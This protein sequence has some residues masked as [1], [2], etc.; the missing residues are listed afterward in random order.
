M[1]PWQYAALAAVGALCVGGAVYWMTRP[2]SDGWVAIPVAQG[3]L[4]GVFYA[5]PDYY[6]RGGVRVPM[7]APEAQR[8]ADA[9]GFVLP[10]PRMVDAIEQQATLLPFHA[11]AV[12]TPE[13]VL[14][15]N[16][17]IEADIAGRAGLFAGH[18]KDIV[19]GAVV[20]R[21][22]GKVVIYGG[23]YVD[24][25]RVQPL[26]AIHDQNYADYSHGVRKIRSVMTVNGREMLVRDVLAD[27]QLYALVSDQPTSAWRYS[28]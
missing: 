21:N 15:Q 6:A 10:T 3:A 12:R 26:S 11:H 16:A 19:V 22:P 20:G 4:Q 9:E 7:T 5:S 8:T 17:E 24:G 28:V 2:S 27:P 23:R 13:T 14:Q 18:K 1:E 25:T